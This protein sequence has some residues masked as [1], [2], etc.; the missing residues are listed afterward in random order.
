MGRTCSGEIRTSYMRQKQKNGDIYV[1]EREIK[2]D[3]TVKYTRNLSYKLIGKIKP[4][5]TEI[6]PTRA[7]KNSKNKNTAA[8]ET[9]VSQTETAQIGTASPEDVKESNP[10]ASASEEVRLEAPVT[11]GHNSEE[12]TPA[13]PM[14]KF[15]FTTQ[16]VGSMEILE[17]IGQQS[18]IDE[19]L[20][21]VYDR[22][23]ANK[24]IAISRYWLS[25]DGATLTRM[26]DWQKSHPTP[27]TDCTIYRSTYQKLFTALGKE[28]GLQYN[29]FRARGN[30]CD[31][32][33]MLAIDSTTV[34]TYSE[35]LNSARWGF[36]KD[37]DGLQTVKLLTAYSVKSNQPI[38][39]IRQ[40]GNIPDGSSIQNALEKLGQIFDTGDKDKFMP[41]IITDNGF[42]NEANMALYVQNNI[43]FLTLIKVSTK[44]V[45]Q[46][47]K[48][49]RDELEKL[50]SICPFDKA[51]HGYT[52]K[53]E[54][55]F[56]IKND[57]TT[58]KKNVVLYLHIYLN[59]NRAV[60]DEIKL[61]NKINELRTQVENGEKIFTKSA[62]KKI[63]NFITI[64]RDDKENITD[65]K[66]NNDEWSKEKKD[67][68]IFCLVSNKETDPFEAL[69]TYRLR[70][71]IEELFNAQ[72][73]NA[74]GDTIRVRTDDSLKGRIF[75]QFIS[76]GY[77]CYYRNAVKK[78]IA[79]LKDEVSKNKGPN[80]ALKKNLL[81]WLN[82]K[83]LT[84]ILDWFECIEEVHIEGP[85]FNITVRSE[86]TKRDRLFIKMLKETAMPEPASQTSN[87]NVETSKTE[88]PAQSQEPH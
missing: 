1:F 43:K 82:Q 25:S 47:I 79:R 59:R 24:I 66:F 64:T 8:S 46:E 38:A 56:T 87:E 20:R 22:G 35:N 2:Y 50:E 7:K 71:K 83:S 15:T 3:P 6:V 23:T 45:H 49:H 12:S 78:V 29:F 77:W 76:L 33:D 65:I 26:A 42:C 37:N 81:S 69:Y 14:P 4:G 85:Q 57:N 62:Q 60:E 32:S 19:D 31:K 9:V 58:E 52:A 74:D 16:H 40:P 86:S 55:E 36:N 13:E 41:Q 53:V 54:H 11:E 10:A 21:A 30:R 84:N 5:T 75:S 88:A 73:N 27:C 34:S 70:E 68:G 61:S 18:G 63:D 28:E 80:C 39:T 44:W 72:K 51:I 67:L 48:A 17:W